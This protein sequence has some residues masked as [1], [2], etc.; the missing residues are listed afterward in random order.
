MS[1]A[2]TKLEKIRRLLVSIE[3]EIG[4]CRRLLKGEVDG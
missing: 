4:E 3:N 2:Q 1:E